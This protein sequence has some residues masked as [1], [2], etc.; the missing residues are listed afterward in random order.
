[1]KK[2]FEIDLAASPKI[3]HAYLR[4]TMWSLVLKCWSY[5]KFLKTMNLKKKVFQDNEKFKGSKKQTLYVVVVR[6]I[7]KVL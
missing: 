4:D 1:M 3:K 6:F 5:L 7:K 2:I